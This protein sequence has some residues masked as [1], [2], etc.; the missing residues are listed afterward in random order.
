[1]ILHVALPILLI[2]GCA[3]GIP[4]LIERLV[5]ETI[6]GLAL[7]AVLSAGALWMISAAIFAGVYSLQAPSSQM[8]AL[9]GRSDGIWHLLNLGA[10]AALIWAPVLA[11]VVTTAPRRWKTA[12][13]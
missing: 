3:I 1:M 7:G 10:K 12:V 5:P 8:I 9:L 11:L 13:W 2:L 4:R 6:P